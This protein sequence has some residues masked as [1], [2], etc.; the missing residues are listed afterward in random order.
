MADAYQPGRLITALRQLR[1]A[2]NGY[3]LRSCIPKAL[4]SDCDKLAQ[5]GL[6]RLGHVRSANG[7]PEEAFFTPLAAKIYLA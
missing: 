1:L 6:V 3:S 2:N 4:M 7:T 5:M